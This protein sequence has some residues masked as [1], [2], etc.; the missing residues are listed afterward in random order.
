MIF[1]SYYMFRNY[2]HELYIYYYIYYYMKVYM[3]LHV[4]FTCFEINYI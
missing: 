2:L 4:N 1:T 3:A